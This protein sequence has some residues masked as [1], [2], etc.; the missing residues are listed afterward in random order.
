MVH[1]G[2]GLGRKTSS[3]SSKGQQVTRRCPKGLGGAECRPSSQ[4]SAWKHCLSLQLL[5]T[6][7]TAVA[8]ER[9]RWLCCLWS[10]DPF[11]LA[12][13]HHT[14]WSRGL[15]RASR[16]GWG[17]QSAQGPAGE[18]VQGSSEVSTGDDSGGSCGQGM[19]AGLGSLMEAAHHQDL[20]TGLH[21][22]PGVGGRCHQRSL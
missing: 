8:L 18:S 16:A 15:S 6:A 22:W 19:V 12:E 13:R 5:S 11:S 20:G 9:S 17:W 7:A 4:A 14:A 10:L 21:V 1:T 3:P 2:E